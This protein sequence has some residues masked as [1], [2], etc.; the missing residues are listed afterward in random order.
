LSYYLQVIQEKQ[1]PLK[2]LKKSEAIVRNHQVCEVEEPI[3]DGK[4]WLL[5][6]L[7][8]DGKT[9]LHR[10]PNVDAY[11]EYSTVVI[12]HLRLIV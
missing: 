8:D 11:E 7:N 2:T 5:P 12:E 10:M 6:W 9:K 1:I 4:N 3:I